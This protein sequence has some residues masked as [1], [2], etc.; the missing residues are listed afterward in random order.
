MFPESIF[1]KLCRAEPPRYAHH[2]VKEILG[3]ALGPVTG[4]MQVKWFMGLGVRQNRTDFW[5]LP[6]FSDN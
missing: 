3:Y 5:G 6:L 2:D 4:V 1:I